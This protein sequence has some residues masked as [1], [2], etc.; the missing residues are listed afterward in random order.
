[1]YEWFIKLYEKPEINYIDHMT[2]EWRGNNSLI[3][4]LHRDIKKKSY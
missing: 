2:A 1:M 3:D 4:Y